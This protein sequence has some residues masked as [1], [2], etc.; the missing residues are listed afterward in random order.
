[1]NRT[2]VVSPS[3]LSKTEQRLQ[4]CTYHYLASRNDVALDATYTPFFHL[5]FS[6]FAF[7]SP[8]IP[9]F[10]KSTSGV[11]SG[12]HLQDLKSPEEDYLCIM[13]GE[14]FR[15]CFNRIRKRNTGYHCWRGVYERNRQQTE[16]L[17]GSDFGE[18]GYLSPNTVLAPFLLSDLFG[19]LLDHFLLSRLLLHI[20][21]EFQRLG[22]RFR[23]SLFWWDDVW[24]T[25]DDQLFLEVV[26]HLV[27][28]GEA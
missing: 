12:R 9:L 23:R 28:N 14:R 20:W 4:Q 16:Y 22:W 19:D 6:Q 8:S 17:N 18:T 27:D 2:T 21:S 1:M 10:D 11:S 5:P 15:Q 13:F 24:T 7:L 25:H 3:P 26:E